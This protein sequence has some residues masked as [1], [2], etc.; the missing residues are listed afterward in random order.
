MIK[1]SKLIYCSVNFSNQGTVK[2]LKFRE[3]RKQQGLV[4][5]CPNF[6]FP[7]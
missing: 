1:T 3:S 4:N 2:A 6:P 5:R 7:G